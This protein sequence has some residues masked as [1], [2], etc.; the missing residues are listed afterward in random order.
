MCAA[1]RRKPLVAV[2]AVNVSGSDSRGG[3]LQQ[4]EPE[5]SG[6]T[7]TMLGSRRR[8]T[9][10]LRRVPAT[11]TNLAEGEYLLETCCLPR[12]TAAAAVLQHDYPERVVLDC[13]PLA[14]PYQGRR[15]RC[16][17]RRSPRRRRHRE[18][19]AARRC[20]PSAP[21]RGRSAAPRDHC[22]PWSPPR[23]L[24]VPPPEPPLRQPRA[25]RA[26]KH[27]EGGFACRSH[28]SWCRGHKFD[29]RST[30]RA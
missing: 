1:L 4:L 23:L 18:A 30:C 6:E 16:C 14:G 27:G 12:Y 8:M 3:L 21:R 2:L 22:A 11:L 20:A 5:S 25:A 7:G 10:L 13:I 28:G 17:R 15:G 9:E 24:H 19:P 26:R 29:V